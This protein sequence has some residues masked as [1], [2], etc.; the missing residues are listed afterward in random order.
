MSKKSE[1]ELIVRQFMQ[2]EEELHHPAYDTELDFYE[3]VS[4]GKVMEQYSELHDG[5]GEVDNPSR[6]ILSGN[7]VR[8]LRYHIIV[9]VAMISRFCIEKGMEQI[10]SYGLSDYYIRR[11]DE[12]TT[13]DELRKI[14]RECILDYSNR[15]RQITARTVHSV[16]CIKAMKYVQNHLHENISLEEV[17]KKVGLERTYFCRL[18][19]KSVGISFTEYVARE[20]IKAACRMLEHSEYNCTEI[21]QFLGFS[22]DSY[23]GKIFKKYKGITPAQYRKKMYERHWSNK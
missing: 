19:A 12:A 23:F 1:K 6:G 8:N 5:Y 18:F 21:G 2:W 7:R 11:L 22:S 9:T 10:E 20:K 17:S 16:Q 15:M 3:A 4:D 14:H 13:E